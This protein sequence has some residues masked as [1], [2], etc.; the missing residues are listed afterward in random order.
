MGKDLSC[1]ILITRSQSHVPMQPVIPVEPLVS[2]SKNC[3]GSGNSMAVSLAFGL[4]KYI[5][6]PEELS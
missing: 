4:S 6:S 2:Q 5:D 3:L 1:D